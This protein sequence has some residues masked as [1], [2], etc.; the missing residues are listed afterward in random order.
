MGAG[1]CDYPPCDCSFDLQPDPHEDILMEPLESHQRTC[2]KKV[3]TGSPS[4]S[5]CLPLPWVTSSLLSN[6]QRSPVRPAS[7]HRHLTPKIQP[8]TAHLA[9][10]DLSTGE[11]ANCTMPILIAGTDARPS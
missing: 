9:A 7:L 8:T 3:V 4:R 6:H 10:C 5:L 1:R 2:Y 11:D